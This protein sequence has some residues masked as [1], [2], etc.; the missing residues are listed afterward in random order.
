MRLKNASI[1][2]ISFSIVCILLAKSAPQLKEAAEKIAV[3]IG[4]CGAITFARFME[5]ALYCPVYGYY[6]K[7]EDTI[8]QKGDFY[9]SVSVGPLFGE[10]LARQFSGWIEGLSGRVQ[11]VEAGAH[12]GR[13]AR[14]VLNWLRLNQPEFLNRLEY[15]LVEPSLRRREWQRLSLTDCPTQVRWMEALPDA[16][17]VSGIIFSNELLDALPVHRLGWD[18]HKRTWFELAVTMRGE[19]FVW[20]RAQPGEQVLELAR[21]RFAE[22]D[23]LSQWLPDGY[24]TELCPAAEKWWTDA[25]RAL[26]SG[27]LLTFDYGF[28]SDG[29]LRPERKEGT[30]RAYYRHQITSDLLARPGEQDLTAHVDFS[31]LRAAGERAGLTTELFTTQG[32]FLTSIAAGLWKN[33][34]GENWTADK[35]REFQT[36]THPE[37][38]GERFHVLVQLKAQADN[39]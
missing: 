12:R 2:A 15:V 34:T 26:R 14:D 20:T 23:V 18:T 32:R 5:V 38:L 37:H 39:S 8:G 1:F 7:E 33:D 25:A 30:L 6:E 24:T 35:M 13:L 16:G 3:E 10:L 17:S 9:T 29:V 28:S 22:S 36:L 21:Q 31:A 27:R 19:D 11:L 4:R